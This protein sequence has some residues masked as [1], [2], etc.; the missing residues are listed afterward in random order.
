VLQHDRS[1][2]WSPDVA[3]LLLVWQKAMAERPE[4]VLF[5]SDLTD[6]LERHG[7]AAPSPRRFL[8]G[9]RVKG[10][11]LSSSRPVI[12]SSRWSA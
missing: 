1:R 12:R 9:P 3:G 2:P 5:F 7:S 8:N 6:F 4:Q 11:T 10:A